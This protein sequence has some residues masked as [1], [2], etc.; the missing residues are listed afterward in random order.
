M[1]SSKKLNYYSYGSLINMRYLSLSCLT[2][3]T[4]VIISL[5][6][7]SRIISKG[8]DVYFSSTVVVLAE[9]LKLAF[10]YGLILKDSGE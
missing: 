4:T 7:Y 8:S 2:C 6:S 3:Q 1:T 10:C 5:Y 9:I